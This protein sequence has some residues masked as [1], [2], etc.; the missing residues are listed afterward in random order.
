MERQRSL[1]DTNAL[2][3][4]ADRTTDP[5]RAA[6][7]KFTREILEKRLHRQMGEVFEVSA[8]ERM[9]NRG[10]LRDWEK[11][12]ASLRRQLKTRVVN[13]VRAACNRGL[14]RLSA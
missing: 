5:E 1:T 4:K 14:Q 6:A 12:L 11:L 8:A 3:N 10:P 7:V 2:I 9:E 13:L